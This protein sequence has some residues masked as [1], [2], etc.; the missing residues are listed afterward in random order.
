MRRSLIALSLA[1]AAFTAACSSAAPSWTYAPPTAP[2]SNQPSASGGASAA[3]SSAASEAPSAAASDNG[4]QGGGDS[5]AI[6]ALNI[7][8]EQKE[9][10]APADKAFS[11]AFDNKDSGIPH[12][13]EIKDANGGQAFMGEIITGPAQTTYNVNALAAGTY[14]FVC[15]VHPN[16]VGTLKVGS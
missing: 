4:G 5:V 10:T 12:N 14:Q 11:I 6:S 8:F 13:I 7:A 9:A 15:T 1:L 3:P 2:P 16:M